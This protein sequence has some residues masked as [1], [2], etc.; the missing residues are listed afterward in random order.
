M[1]EKI[2]HS[3]HCYSHAGGSKFYPYPNILIFHIW[4]PPNPGTIKRQAK[5]DWKFQ[6]PFHSG[7]MSLDWPKYKIFSSFRT[8]TY[9]PFE[10]INWNLYTRWV[11]IEG[12]TRLDLGLKPFFFRSRVMPLENIIS[13]GVFYCSSVVSQKRSISVFL[14]SEDLRSLFYLFLLN[15]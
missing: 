1:N 6:H 14:H 11:F 3:G 13:W 2:G 10:Q 5:L 15:R 4:F 12:Q 7:A 8:I 9:V